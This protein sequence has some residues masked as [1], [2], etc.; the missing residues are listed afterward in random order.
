[1]SKRFSWKDFFENNVFFY[2]NTLEPML[3]NRLAITKGLKEVH[4]L[5]KECKYKTFKK[6]I[7]EN[8]ELI[9]N[10]FQEWI[11]SKLGLEPAKIYETPQKANKLF[12]DNRTHFQKLRQLYLQITSRD[13]T[14]D[15]E[16]RIRDRTI[17]ELLKYTKDNTRTPFSKS[18]L[19]KAI[20][21]FFNS[22]PKLYSWDELLEI[23]L[24]IF[25]NPKTIPKQ[26]VQTKPFSTDIQKTNGSKTNVQE[27]IVAK[28]PWKSRYKVES[29][30]ER[31]DWSSR[32]ILH[33]TATTP[34][35]TFRMKEQRKL[36][37][38]FYGPRFSF[39]IDYMFA[40]KFAY[41]IAINMNTRKAFAFPVQKIQE[42]NDFWKVPKNVKETAEE[43]IKTLQKLL[44]ET[45]G[46]VRFLHSDQEQIW[47]SEEWKKFLKNNN[48]EH[49]FYVKNS[50]NN[51]IETH[52]KSRGN[53]STTSLVDRLIRTLRLMAYNLTNKSQIDPDMMKYL[54]DEYNNSP[55]S[56]LTKYLKKPTCPNEVDSNVMLEQEFVKELMVENMFVKA[57]PQYQVR[58]YVRVYN[59]A[60]DMDKVKPKLLPGKWEVVGSNN[61]LLKLKQGKNEL[62]VNRWMVK[63]T[64]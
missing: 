24:R 64:I 33:H 20:L 8:T 62:N 22:N 53:H 54:I 32:D 15:Y 2:I 1:M 17:S 34:A 23:H 6:W 9:P 63:N 25:N 38:H 51:I 29:F 3:R 19:Q 40:G 41:L 27:R 58:K 30:G 49:I 56:T 4:K 50:F 12:K 36:M 37:K 52:D 31:N 61:G 47:K 16:I 42:T 48:I 21:P 43:A 13:Y 5:V 7:L 28:S 57:R 44:N 59:N 35:D 39:V 14:E 45:N 26:K 46:N 55:H 60:H 18:Q 11:F 10:Q